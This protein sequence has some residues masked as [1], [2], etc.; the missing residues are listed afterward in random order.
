M[1][2]TVNHR[3]DSSVNHRSRNISIVAACMACWFWAGLAIMACL[4]LLA[5]LAITRV[6][7]D[8]V[9]QSP[10]FR[11]I[12]LA[13]VLL[14]AHGATRLPGL[15]IEP[16]RLYHYANR[17][18]DDAFL[19]GSAL[20]AFALAAAFLVIVSGLGQGRRWAIWSFVGM[21]SVA[22]LVIAAYDLW[23]LSQGAP[24]DV[25][26]AI[27]FAAAVPAS[28]AATSCRQPIQ[29]DPV[30]HDPSGRRNSLMRPALLL[31]FSAHALLVVPAFACVCVLVGVFV[32]QFWLAWSS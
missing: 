28:L 14:N 31:L 13:W 1:L 10:L 3:G 9:Q 30:E 32:R 20:I 15:N 29:P 5:L 24:A 22:A 21:T 27:A 16:R 12:C 17:D 19:I 25:L 2:S 11:L 7:D 26:A 8:G 18:F 4:A 23:C 6:W